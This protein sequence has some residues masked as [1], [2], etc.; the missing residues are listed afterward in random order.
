MPNDLRVSCGRMFPNVRQQALLALCLVALNALSWHWVGHAPASFSWFAV[1]SVTALA[2]VL[3]GPAARM[4]SPVCGAFL[5]AATWMIPA[6]SGSDF[7]RWLRTVSSAWDYLGLIAELA[8]WAAVFTVAILLQRRWAMRLPNLPRLSGDAAGDRLVDMLMALSPD[9]LGRFQP[10]AKKL[11]L[12]EGMKPEIAV[13]RLLAGEPPENIDPLRGEAWLKRLA[14]AVMAAILGA[15][16]MRF[17]VPNAEP[18]QV[19]W[20][21]FFAFVLATM[22]THQVFPVVDAMGL[23]LSPFLTAA[24]TY[25]WMAI[26]GSSVD[27][28]L[29]TYFTRHLAGGAMVMPMVYAAAG[30]AGAAAGVGWS[31]AQIFSHAIDA[32]RPQAEVSDGVA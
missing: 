15:I 11:G 29:T 24:G 23:F 30:V 4:G 5:I 7:D 16:F 1:M 12:P 31:R 21:T 10:D 3:A 9:A 27:D 2:V 14:G 28:L 25:G 26:A 22:L 20:G 13:E 6:A 8:I 17:L 18:G 19:L 32:A